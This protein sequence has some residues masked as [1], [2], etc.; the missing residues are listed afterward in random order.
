M[1]SQVAALKRQGLRAELYNSS[2]NA[3]SKSLL[4]KRLRGMLNR[5]PVATLGGAAA[6]G[7]VQML[8]CTPEGLQGAEL[9][10]LLQGLAAARMLSL[11][12]VDEAHCISSWGH[13]FRSVLQV[14][15]SSL[16]VTATNVLALPAPRVWCCTIG[17]HGW[18]KSSQ[19]GHTGLPNP[20]R[21]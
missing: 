2:L 12:A 3:A 1:C 4:Q 18:A 11:F 20:L 15:K 10:G 16:D 19:R 6:A 21:E 5:T 8:Y 9:R 17:R 7:D 13:D 14:P